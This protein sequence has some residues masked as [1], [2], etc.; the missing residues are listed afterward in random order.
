MSDR[1]YFKS[2]DFNSEPW[3]LLSPHQESPSEHAYKHLDVI[4]MCESISDANDAD[5][6]LGPCCF[7][8]PKALLYKNIVQ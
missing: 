4:S 7:E 5:D 6:G 3:D 1:N 8:T 2:L